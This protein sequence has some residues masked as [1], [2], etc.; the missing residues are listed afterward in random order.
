MFKSSTRRSGRMSADESWL[1][2]FRSG[3]TS[4][5]SGSRPITPARPSSDII[6]V[7]AE[8]ADI[9]QNTKFRAVR[10][11]PLKILKCFPLTKCIR[12]SN[13]YMEDLLSVNGYPLLQNLS[14]L[15]LGSCF[16]SHVVNISVNLSKYILFFEL[17]FKISM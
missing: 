15:S 2:H 10:P 5:S 6:H 12:L 4:Q 16:E 8:F 1:R 14:L 13:T 3:R 11:F 17:P 7:R 9:D